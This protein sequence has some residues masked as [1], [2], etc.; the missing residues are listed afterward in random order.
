MDERTRWEDEEE[1]MGMGRIGGEG[2]LYSSITSSSLH[3][4]IPLG[5]DHAWKSAD[6]VLVHVVIPPSHTFWHETSQHHSM[7]LLRLWRHL[8]RKIIRIEFHFSRLSP[9]E[10]PMERGKI[11]LMLSYDPLACSLVVRSPSLLT[12]F[13]IS[14]LLSFFRLEFC[15]VRIF[16]NSLFPPLVNVYSILMSNCNFYRI[17]ITSEEG[18]DPI[19][20]GNSFAY[21]P[22]LF[23]ENVLERLHAGIYVVSRWSIKEYLFCN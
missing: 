17:E 3:E 11:N 9:S 19:N 7:W 12:P 20:Y 8:N 6:R 13:L 14:N 21:K 10:L 1:L 5:I 2:N 15:H 18:R 22:W 23:F 16:V 4:M